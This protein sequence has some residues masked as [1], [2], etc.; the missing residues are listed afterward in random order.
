MCA[1]NLTSSCPALQATEDM[2]Q[3][4][5]IILKAIG[6]HALNI[7]TS[8]VNMTKSLDN[9]EACWTELL[10]LLVDNKPLIYS[11]VCHFVSMVSQ[12]STIIQIV[13]F[14]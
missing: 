5:C 1:S 4:L 10:N 14:S 6:S 7:V 2:I 9:I 11:T 12:H 13:I 8:K 3:K